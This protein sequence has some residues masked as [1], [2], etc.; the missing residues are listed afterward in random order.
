MAPIAPPID[1]RHWLT[2]DPIPWSRLRGRVVVPVFWSF[3]CEASLVMLRRLT[4]RS[5]AW[6]PRVTLLAVHS[7]RFAY[8]HDLDRVRAAVDRHRL[9]VPVINDPDGLTWRRYSP[10]GWPACVVIDGRGRVLGL[11]AGTP[12][13]PVIDEAVADA[14]DHSTDCRSAPQDPADHPTW[15]GTDRD[16]PAE[17][18]PASDEPGRD[19]ERWRDQ[20]PTRWRP[21]RPSTLWFPSA[22]ATTPGGSLIV[23]DTGNDRL[24]IGRL[25]PDRRTFRP[26]A[27]I[28]DVDQPVAVAAVGESTL[29]VAEAGTGDVLRVDLDHGRLD[30]V[31]DDLLGPAALLVDRDGSLVVADA[32]LD[33]LVRIDGPTLD[34]EAPATLDGPGMGAIAG[35]GLTGRSDGRAARAELAQPVALART[36]AGIV[37]CDAATSNVR[38]LTDDGRVHTVTDNDFFGWG[39]VD[40]P[41]HRARLQRPSGLAALGDGAIVIADTGNDRLRVLRHRRLTTVGVAGLDQPTGLAALAS[42]QVVVADTGNHRLVVVDLGRQ[43]AWPLAVYPATSTSVWQPTTADG[44][45]ATET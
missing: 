33:R 18:G 5:R 11:S 30:L 41:A 3:G 32:G 23:G 15:P 13:L 4:E 12:G 38:L 2:T 10:G 7:P 1:G 8:E 9:T 40:G 39:L 28:T 19:R 21:P 25:D 14:V 20:R 31:T 34:G 16:Q 24:L 22:V 37:F 35:S 17:G 45:P 6:G 43:T 42:N 36:P 26:S 27:E 44:G 29:F